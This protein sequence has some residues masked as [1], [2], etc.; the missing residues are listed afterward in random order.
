MKWIYFLLLLPLSL[1][2]ETMKA[3]PA[4]LSQK[5][6]ARITILKKFGAYL[7]NSKTVPQL[8]ELSPYLVIDSEYQTNFEKQQLLN[9]L[10]TEL[11]KAMDTLNLEEYDAFPWLKYPYAEKLPKMVWEAESVSHIM[12]TPIESK[13]QKQEVME[14]RKQLEFILVIFAKTRPEVPLYFALFDEKADKIRSWLLLNQGGL[15]YFLL[16]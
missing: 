11:D 15:H 14:G 8:T 12:G 16:L 2:S 6:Q 10:L 1:I 4:G 7:K 9:G 5:E 13:D 3:Q